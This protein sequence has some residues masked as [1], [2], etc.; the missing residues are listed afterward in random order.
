M[1]NNISR[2]WP[3]DWELEELSAYI[4]WAVEQFP[5]FRNSFRNA[6][7]VISEISETA[8]QPAIL[9]LV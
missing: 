2:E 8:S 4:A 9:H 1:V 6:V 7:S 5:A 3:R